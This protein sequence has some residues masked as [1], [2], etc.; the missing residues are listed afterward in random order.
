M[1]KNP[2][3]PAVILSMTFLTSCAGL[4]RPINPPHVNYTNNTVNEGISFSYRYDVLREIGNKKYAKKERKHGLKVVAIKLTNNYDV[5]FKIGSDL[6]LYTG[7]NPVG[8]L[9]P[10][11]AKRLLKQSAPTY[12]LYLLLTDLQL[13]S[14]DSYGRVTESVPIGLALGPG[15]ALGNLATAASSNKKLQREL[16][17]YNIAGREIQPGETIYG[18]IVI[19]QYG[20]DPISVKLTEVISS[21]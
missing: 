3:L 14:T 16:I 13:Y 10:M 19:R 7:E 12:L 2:L 11:I 18:L 5:P 17:E 15:I 21:N 20:Y 9:D 8:M 1:R 4:Y 6:V